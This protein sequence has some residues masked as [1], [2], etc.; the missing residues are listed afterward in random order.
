[1]IAHISRDGRTEST[2]EHTRKVEKVIIPLAR[3]I[4]I[5]NIMVLCAVLHDFGKEKR[6]FNNYILLDEKER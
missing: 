2:L 3:K 1:M 6:E 5:E 4:G